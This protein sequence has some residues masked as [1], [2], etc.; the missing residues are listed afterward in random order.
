MD[1]L[2]FYVLKNSKFWDGCKKNTYFYTT[3]KLKAI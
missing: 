3:I 2:L 1:Q